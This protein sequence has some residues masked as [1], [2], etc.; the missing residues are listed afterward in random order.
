MKGS[1]AVKQY[2]LDAGFRYSGSCNCGGM[3][4]NKYEINTP[5]GLMQVRARASHYLMRVGGSPY[6]K[7]AMSELKP[8]VDNVKKIIAEAGSNAQA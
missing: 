1:A 7:Y 2:M 6:I 8:M 5:S 4:T 3:F